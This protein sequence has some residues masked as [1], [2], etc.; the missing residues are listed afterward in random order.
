MGKVWTK[1]AVVYKLIALFDLAFEG[2]T[3]SN[4]KCHGVTHGG[5][6]S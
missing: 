4:P 2:Q 3:D 1:W 6:P 5:R